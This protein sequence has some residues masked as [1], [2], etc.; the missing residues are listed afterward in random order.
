M[1]AMR[2]TILVFLWLFIVE[3][4][5]K[6]RQTASNGHFDLWGHRACRWCGLS[7]CIRI[8]SLKFV[9]LSI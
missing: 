8:P 3:L 7:Y 2:R 1:L 9:G 6:K 5:A 4:W